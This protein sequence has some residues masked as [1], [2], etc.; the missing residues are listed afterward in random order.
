MNDIYYKLSM[1]KP[2]Y[3]SEYP[4]LTEVKVVECTNEDLQKIL[5]DLEWKTVRREQ[6]VRSVRWFD[7]EK[8][9]SI[10]EKYYE[11]SSNAPPILWPERNYY[12]IMID[13]F[14]RRFKRF[15]KLEKK[16]IEAYGG[17]DMFRS[18]LEVNECL[19]R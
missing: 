10:I 15:L 19:Q 16:L 13:R 5:D 12:P 6:K 8:Y 3:A 1:K 17:I 9:D 11:A 2:I 4:D 7:E 14:E 18:C